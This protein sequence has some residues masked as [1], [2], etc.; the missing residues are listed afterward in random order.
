MSGGLGLALGIWMGPGL[1]GGLITSIVLSGNTTL[2]S[3][4]V[5]DDV[6]TASINGP[7]TGTPTWS[8]SN[9]AGGKYSID[10]STG[11]LEVAGALAAGTDTITIAVSGVTPAI[12]STSFDILVASSIDVLV[13]ES[14]N[15][16]V[17]ESG[18]T[19]SV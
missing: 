8:L 16:V 2:D 6:G 4:A 13:D 17:D 3:A 11:L 5:G 19:V 7:S 14:G 1:R 9:S 10:S 12:I 15:V 18:N